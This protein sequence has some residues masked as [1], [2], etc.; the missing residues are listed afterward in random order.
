MNIT[1]ILG[2]AGNARAN[3]LRRQLP[4]AVFAS[5]AQEMVL[6]ILGKAGAG[7]RIG[8][9]RI[10]DLF[11]PTKKS[12]SHP[13]TSVAQ[14]VR[15][16]GLFAPNGQLEVITK[17][18]GQSGGATPR[19][20]GFGGGFG[21]GIGGFAG[22][23]GGGIGGFAGQIGGGFG[24]FS[25][26]LQGGFGG[27]FGGQGFGGGLQGGFGGGAGGFGGQFGGGSG[28]FG[29]QLG[30]GFGG[31]IGG[32]AGQFGGGFGGA[33]GG[34]ATSGGRSPKGSLAE[35]LAHLL[36]VATRVSS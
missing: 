25:G 27:Q 10:I 4:D 21:G 9:L 8:H 36:G 33:G 1:V 30:G 23:F 24:G 3:T 12:G 16:R 26:G 17:A 5:T 22:Q 32:F 11:S 2:E 14:L 34:G 28:G 31:G 13:L 7:G 29:G 35:F 6:G 20:G 19:S 18:F 15:L